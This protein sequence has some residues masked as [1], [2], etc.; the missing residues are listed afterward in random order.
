MNQ[1]IQFQRGDVV[2]VPFP[3]VTD[4]SQSKTRPAVVIQGDIGNLYSPNLILAL[5]SST[6]PR[7]LY[8]MHY[9]IN[10]ESSVAMSAGLQQDSI[11][12][13]EVIITLPKRAILQKLGNLPDYAMKQVDECIKVS[14]GL[15]G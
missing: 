4:Y 5:I 11:V 3:Y 1:E 12:K 14:L 15:K 10:A 6:I 2:L 13:T 9:R 8:P 7:K